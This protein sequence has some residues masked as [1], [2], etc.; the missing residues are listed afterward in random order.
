MINRRIERMPYFLLLSRFLK[1]ETELIFF[2]RSSSLFSAYFMSP[3]ASNQL[4]IPTHKLYCISHIESF[5]YPIKKSV[6]QTGAIELAVNNKRAN[7]FIRT[8]F[9]TVYL[10]ST[11]PHV[12]HIIHPISK[13]SIKCYRKKLTRTQFFM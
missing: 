1:G 6:A 11:L 7:L 5:T 12:F 2:V 8:S 4:K 9:C 3:I 13:S 10:Y